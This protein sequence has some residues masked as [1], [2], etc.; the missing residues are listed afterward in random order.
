MWQGRI[1]HSSEVLLVID[2]E[3]THSTS[4]FLLLDLGLYVHFPLG[5][6]LSHHIEIVH[7]QY[8]GYSLN[9]CFPHYPSSRGE[10]PADKHPKQPACL[11]S[12]VNYRPVI[13]LLLW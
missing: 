1:H 8:T 12:V 6:L 10:L 4:L 5:K 9:S 7:R 3:A 2:A 13:M 11:S